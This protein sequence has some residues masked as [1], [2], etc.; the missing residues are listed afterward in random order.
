MKKWISNSLST[1]AVAGLIA[2]AAL[3]TPQTKAKMAVCPVCKMPLYMKKSAAHPVAV[4]LKKG[5]PVMYCCPQCKMPASMLV[6]P[7]VKRKVGA[8]AIKD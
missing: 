5:G 8:P 1:L 7:K 2:G 3:A 6:K 4:R